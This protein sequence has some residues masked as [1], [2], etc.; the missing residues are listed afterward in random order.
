MRLKL[1]FAVPVVDKSSYDENILTGCIPAGTVI[2][3]EEI[4]DERDWEPEEGA[5]FWYVSSDGT[6]IRSRF[7]SDSSFDKSLI[8][9]GNIFQTEELAFP[10]A[11]KM[12]EVFKR[13]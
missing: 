13:K 5:Y 10:F 2:E 9:A 12:R 4:K 1:N 8:H 11:Q 6:L 3:V 7:A